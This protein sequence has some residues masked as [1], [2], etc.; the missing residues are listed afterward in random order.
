MLLKDILGFS[1][2]FYLQWQRNPSEV[3]AGYYLLE[4]KSIYV[5]SYFSVSLLLQSALVTF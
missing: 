2:Q 3:I 5:F 4:Q 1:F